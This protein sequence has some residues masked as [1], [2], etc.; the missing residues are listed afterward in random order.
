MPPF[1]M[2][3]P[4][5]V[6]VVAAPQ[7]FARVRR[8]G[9]KNASDAQRK[10]AA[11]GQSRIEVRATAVTSYGARYGILHPVAFPPKDV[12]GFQ[13]KALNNFVASQAGVLVDANI[14]N[15]RRA[16]ARA[17]FNAPVFLHVFR[18][19]SRRLEIVHPSVPIRAQPAGPKH[20]RGTQG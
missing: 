13:V 11:V 12:S 19:L 9:G 18:P 3:L 5:A 6:R 15:E 20:V 4:E 1:G 16:S 2:T 14:R 10:E 17:D 8:P 7:K